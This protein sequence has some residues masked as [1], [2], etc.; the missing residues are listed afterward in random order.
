MKTS[1]AIICCFSICSAAALLFAGDAPAVA[2]PPPPTCPNCA[3]EEEEAPPSSTVTEWLEPAKRSKVDLDFELTTQD[4]KKIKLKD[5]LD[6]P[7]AVGF[8]F[9]RCGN[10]R[11][12]PL[13]V[14]TM[15]QLQ[16]KA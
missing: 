12:C 6:K 2:T 4:S 14:A 11:K 13:A 15:A 8:F 5:L 16:T 9:S 1:F 7:A 3:A 10:P